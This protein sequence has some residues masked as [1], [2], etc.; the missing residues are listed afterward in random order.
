[1]KAQNP[2]DNL[3]EHPVRWLT[4]DGP[5]A[6]ITISTRIRLARN[7]SG[8]QFPTK[9]GARQRQQVLRLAREAI[10]A[11]NVM[12]DCLDLEMT[13]LDELDRLFLLER[14]LISREH[15]GTS[16]TSNSVFIAKNENYSVMVNEEDHLRLQVMSAGLKLDEMWRLAD[17]VDSQLAEHLQYAYSEE[18]GF[19][20]SCPTNVGTGIRASVMVHLPGLVC[21]NQIRAIT[22]A[23]HKI[24]FVVRG[25]YGEGSETDG[26]L[27]QISNQSTLGESEVYI[28]EKLD[29]IIRQI[30][31]H[32]RNARQMLLERRPK[33]LYDHIGRAYGILRHAYVLESGEALRHL[34]A[35]RLGVDIGM[36]S[37]VDAK[38]INELLV[39]IQPGHLQK[40]NGRTLNESQRDVARADIVR[41]RLNGSSTQR[42]T[43]QSH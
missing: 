8:I 5:D 16:Q 26:N 11:V 41:G 32:E 4:V 30:I 27:F 10:S 20:T 15:C 17:H 35:I 42:S 9:A 3:L 23:V 29:K 22:Q 6:G 39:N 34:S 14:H 13:T 21:S 19:L 2:I 25:L 40:G 24:G 1:M 37:S 36:F 12:E 33:Y 7:I 18:L 31:E 38:T 43:D 28:I